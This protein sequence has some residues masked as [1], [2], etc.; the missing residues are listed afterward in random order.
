MVPWPA[1]R[2]N[3]RKCTSF[4]FRELGG[5]NRTQ[6]VCQRHVSHSVASSK[7]WKLRRPAAGH[8][9]EECCPILAAQQSWVTFV[10]FNFMMLQIFQVFSWWKSSTAARQHLNSVTMK[11]CCCSRCYKSLLMSRS[12]DI[13]SLHSFY[14][15]EHYSETFQFVDAGFFWFFPT[16]VKLKP[17]LFTLSL[18]PIMLLTC[19]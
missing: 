5:S 4:V 14:V 6:N 12:W 13:Q 3:L 10:Y 11:A 19:S 2:K 8:L 16:L 15:E 17:T 1:F 18:Y 9:W 7:L